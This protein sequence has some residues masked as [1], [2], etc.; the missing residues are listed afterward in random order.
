MLKRMKELIKELQIYNDAYYNRNESI[1]SDFEYDMKYDELVAL[2]TKTGT[3]LTNSPTIQ[4]GCKV[5]TK[6][7]KVEHNHPMLSLDKTKDINM[8]K[9]FLGKKSGLGML[10]MD[11]LTI[12][13]KYDNGVL[14]AA[15]T[16]GNGYI[17][18]DVLH[19]VEVFDNVPL[20]I[21]YK[22]EF[23]VDGEAIIDLD[24]FDK[25]NAPL[26]NEA[27][28]KGKLLGLTGK[29][30]ED[31]ISEHSYKNA[32]NLAS[33]S[34]RQLNSKITLDRKVKF[35]AWK[36]IKGIECDSFIERLSALAS[37]GFE[38][39]PYIDTTQMPLEKAVEALVEEARIKQY[40]I[41]GL[42]FSYNSVSYGDSLGKTEKF[43]R[44]Q[45]AFKF[46]DEEEETKLINIEWS[47]GRTGA[48]TPV[49]IFEPVELEGTTVER[50]SIHNVNIMNELNNNREW[51]RG[52]TLFVHKANQIIP[53]I[54][55]VSFNE[56]EYNAADVVFQIPTVCPAC[57]ETVKVENDM[58]ICP[59]NNCEGKLLNKICNFVSRD[60][61]NINGLSKKSIDKLIAV[62]AIKDFSDIFALNNKKSIMMTMEGFGKKKVENLLTE[63]E[64]SKTV[65]LENFLCALGIPGLGI[66]KCKCINKA[67][68]G[69]YQ[70]LR[71]AIK[72]N[73]N[74]SELEDFGESINFSIYE[75]WKENC[76]LIEKMVP[77]LKWRT[78]KVVTDNLL[79]GKSFVITGKLYKSS[80]TELKKKI[81]DS[82]GKVTDQVSSKTDYLINN[83]IESTSSKN[84]TAKENGIP[85]ITEENF[86][87][88]FYKSA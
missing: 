43:V 66:S 45:L 39:V 29:D 84:K 57:G 77:Y 11:G 37:Y 68:N 63:I 55:S 4:V 42:V 58:I 2:E 40:P 56:E 36:S 7:N 53:Q 71:D 72:E 70:K 60:G 85:I 34:V 28:E 12:T 41:D 17:G 6:L 21:D 65:S 1:I 14:V 31:F 3:I 88:I 18:E 38:V 59:N 8:I 64:N 69:E 79:E 54:S 10:K 46:Y 75:Y 35:I 81:M 16:R 62:G 23:I 67:F 27:K 82:G 86:Y 61:M 9:T 32:R 74:F 76:E 87:K 30:L 83:D 20:K 19:N 52:M 48:I 44:S 15:E 80:R 50:A 33:G 49:A 47:L 25:I 13:L 22:G 73:Y 24:T 78:Y 26:I 5:V 51:Y